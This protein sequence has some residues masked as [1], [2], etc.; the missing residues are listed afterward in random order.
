MIADSQNRPSSLKKLSEEDEVNEVRS[1]GDGD[2]SLRADAGTGLG[3][4][5]D[6]SETRPTPSIL[7]RPVVA[8]QL[9]EPAVPKPS[10]RRN[11]N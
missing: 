6:A 2:D 5:N 8:Y 9:P 1:V 11:N 4:G 3:K 10:L 7:S